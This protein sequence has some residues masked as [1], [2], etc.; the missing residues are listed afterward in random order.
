M[1]KMLNFT[2]INDLSS[3]KKNIYNELYHNKQRHK[4]PKHD[5]I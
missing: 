5:M 2:E 3:R 4:P 1:F